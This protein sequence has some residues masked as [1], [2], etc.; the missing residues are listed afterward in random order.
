MIFSLQL[1]STTNT[2][3]STTKSNTFRNREVI[4]CELMELQ[5]RYVKCAL[6]WEVS[7]KV[8][9]T[10]YCFKKTNENTQKTQMKEYFFLSIHLL[11]KHAQKTFE[12]HL[13]NEKQ[14]Q[15]YFMLQSEKAE[16]SRLE[17]K[18]QKTNSIQTWHVAVLNAQHTHTRT[19]IWTCTNAKVALCR[20]NEIVHPLKT[21]VPSFDERCMGLLAG[22][23]KTSKHPRETIFN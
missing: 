1:V 6:L 4:Y 18:P 21:E 11:A 8:E 2:L 3:K 19:L 17:T 12:E 16:Y 14:R 5:H 9:R 13:K 22:I 15:K 7:V 10:S 23:I 20:S